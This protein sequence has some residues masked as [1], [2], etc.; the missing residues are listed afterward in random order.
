MNPRAMPHF[1]HLVGEAMVST[2]Q[3]FF[4]FFD[5]VYISDCFRD[6]IIGRL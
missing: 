1:S 5:Q 4:F 2:G 3:I 6:K